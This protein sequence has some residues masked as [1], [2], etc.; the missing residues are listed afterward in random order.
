MS[1]GTDRQL[2]RRVSVSGLCFP[3]LTAVESIEVVA[4]LG[5]SAMSMSR[6][7]LL[8]ADLALVAEA[9]RRHGVRIV[10]T[11]AAL[12]FDLSSRASVRDGIAQA[13]ADVDRAAAVGAR[14][15]Y[16]VLG[17][18]PSADWSLAAAAFAEVAAEVVEYA[19]RRGVTVGIEPASSLYADVT[20]LHSFRDAIGIARA[21]G[22]VVCLDL[23]HVW[24]EGSLHDDI[25]QHADLIGH[26][27]VAD[28]VGGDRALPAQSVPGEGIIPLREMIG[29]L[30][31]AGYDG[32]F[33]V[34]LGGPRI[35]AAGQ[36]EAAS[37]AARWVDQTLASARPAARHGLR[38]VDS[39]EPPP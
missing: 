7:K 24:I 20:F 9:G 8:D 30:I 23:F 13:C 25:R 37:R 1:T 21:A 11:T 12:A 14:S 34:E 39:P 19:G 27:Q 17:P 26:V 4:S 10:A 35:E 36:V 15:V 31:E 16:G 18:R 38:L 28:L 22:L 5:V 2:D 33:D 29:W 3:S 32:V 6:Y